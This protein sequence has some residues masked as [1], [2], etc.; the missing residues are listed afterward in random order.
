LIK[1]NVHEVNVLGSLGD[2]WGGSAAELRSR[3]G[4]TLAMVT[5]GPR[6]AVVAGD[7]G[8]WEAIPPPITV[9]SA[10]GSGDSL[11]AAFLWALEQ[12]WSLPEALRL[13]VAAGAANAMTYGAGFCGREQIF[14]LADR[15]QVNKL[16]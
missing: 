6:G 4:I 1:P 2:G 10:V 3:Y 5:G 9:R 11:T 16:G 7:E 12:N 8:I 14:A 15:T 13:G